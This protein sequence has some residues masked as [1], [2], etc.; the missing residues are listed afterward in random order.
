MALQPQARIGDKSLGHWIG[1]FYFPPCTLTEGSPDTFSCCIPASRVGDAATKHFAFIF[2]IVPL[3]AFYHEP[4]ASTGDPKVL[5]N[6]KQAFRVGDSYN[7]GDTQ[8]Q[9]CETNLKCTG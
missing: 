2:G 5:I 9:G 7:C 1:I 4:K 6:Y 3:P 8:A